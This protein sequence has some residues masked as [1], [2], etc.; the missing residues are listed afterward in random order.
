MP[1]PPPFRRTLTVQP[2]SS[3]PRATRTAIRPS[4]CTKGRSLGR[5]TIASSPQDVHENGRDNDSPWSRSSASSSTSASQ[6]T[7]GSRIAAFVRII[8]RISKDR[9]CKSGQNG[10]NIVGFMGFM[11]CG[12]Q[13]SERVCRHF[14][15]TIP[16][17]NLRADS[18]HQTSQHHRHALN[19]TTESWNATIPS[20]LVCEV[21]LANEIDME[22][23]SDIRS[24][25]YASHS[26]NLRKHFKRPL[27][28]QY[29]ELHHKKTTTCF[30]RNSKES[31]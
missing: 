28:N 5:R 8:L 27:G 2:G 14:N 10:C 31:G 21:P 13:E 19:A 3:C 1:S 11:G 26:K 20:S 4:S 9:C 24:C 22:K 15:C 25:F 30:H 16:K 12:R 6:G 17:A 18:Q 29:L 23:A 7:R